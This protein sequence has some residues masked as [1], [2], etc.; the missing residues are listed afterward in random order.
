MYID[1]LNGKID[2]IVYDTPEHGQSKEIM[3]TAFKCNLCKHCRDCQTNGVAQCTF[4]TYLTQK[5]PTTLYSLKNAK[6]TVEIHTLKPDQEMLDKIAST[7]E[8]AKRLRMSGQLKGY[9]KKK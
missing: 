7:I 9:Y 2:V 3:R 8:R 6:P 1:F 4:A 5:L